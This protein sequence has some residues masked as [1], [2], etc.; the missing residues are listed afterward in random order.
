MDAASDRQV[1]EV[2]CKVVPGV[3]V[4][5]VMHR[6]DSIRSYDR[7][8]LIANGSIVED[9]SPQALLADPASKF[10]QLYRSEQQG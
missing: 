9:G 7:V 1:H 3:T 8:V 6:F 2:I 4:L 5:S 10:T